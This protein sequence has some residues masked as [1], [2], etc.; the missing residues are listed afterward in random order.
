M[1]PHG[2]PHSLVALIPSW[3]ARVHRSNISTI[4]LWTDVLRTV[5]QECIEWPNDPIQCICTWCLYGQRLDEFEDKPWKMP[6]N[7]ILCICFKITSLSHLHLYLLPPPWT[8]RILMNFKITFLYGLVITFSAFA[9]DA[10]M[11]RV[12]MS[13]K[14]NLEWWLV[15]TFFAFAL[16]LPFWVS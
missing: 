6:G 15:I 5:M 8:Y 12:L 7:H 2:C 9:L 4:P 14:S 16:R 1:A 10:S 13:L 3:G 11:D